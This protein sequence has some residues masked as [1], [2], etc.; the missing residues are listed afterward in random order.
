MLVSAGLLRAEELSGKVVSATTGR[1]IEGAFVTLGDAVVRTGPDGVFLVEGDSG[2]VGVRAYGHKRTQVASSALVGGKAKVYLSPFDPKALYLSF[3]GISSRPLRN[4]ALRLIDETELNALVIDVKGDRGMTSFKSSGKLAAEAGANKVTTIKDP[5]ALTDSLRRKGI[6]S[7]ARVVIFKDEPLASAKPD[8]AV[9]D[10]DGNVWRDREGLA[11]TDPF[12]EEVWDYNIAIAVEAAKYGFD[13]I[14]FDYVR[15]PDTSGLA[16]SKANTEENRVAAISGL[17]RRAREKLAPYNVFLSADIFGYVCWNRD[18]TAIGQRLED[19]AE[20][21]DYLSPML[22]PSGFSFGIPRY[23]NPVEYPYQIVSLTL[24]RAMARTNLPAVRFRPWL[25]AFQDYAFDKRPFGNE[26]V[27]KQIGASEDFGSNGW[28]LW[29]ARNR[30]EKATL[31]DATP[32]DD[33][34]GN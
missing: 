5:R 20:I 8:W 2:P 27:Q 10:R 30:Y 22:Y 15:F 16:F 7:I 12:R 29:N 13:E 28:M 17:L 34:A 11:W 24:K 14:Q 4:D 3:Y 6:Y 32:A 19:V 26:E 21:V 31:I 1:P 18:D 23:R 9:K 25:Q 33:D